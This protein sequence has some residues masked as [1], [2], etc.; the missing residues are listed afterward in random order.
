[1]SKNGQ[2]KYIKKIIKNRKIHKNPKNT[3]IIIKN[4]KILQ[5]HYKNITEI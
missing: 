1:M 2:K 5:K 3:V 4:K